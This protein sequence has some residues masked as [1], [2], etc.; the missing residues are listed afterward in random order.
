[1]AYMENN[2]YPFAS[3]KLDSIRFDTDGVRATLQIEKGPLYKIDSIR[4][5]GNV[6]IKNHFLQKYLDIE[7][8]SIYRKEKLNFLQQSLKLKV[9]SGNLYY[10]FQN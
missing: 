8:G 3:V 2:G 1:M 9:L 10:L 5:T 4:V 6:K 7:K